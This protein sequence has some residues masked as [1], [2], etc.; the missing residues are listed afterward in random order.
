LQEANRRAARLLEREAAQAGNLR[1]H[2]PR[3]G[4]HS[5]ALTIVDQEVTDGTREQCSL[6][7]VSKDAEIEGLTSEISADTSEKQRGPR[8][9]P[10]DFSGY[11]FGNL[12]NIVAH[13]VS[14]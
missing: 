14:G 1:W 10:M 2:G 8:N 9:R 12:Q 7:E 3:G 13:V 6:T 4:K 11:W 5:S